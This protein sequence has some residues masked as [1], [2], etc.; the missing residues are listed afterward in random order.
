MTGIGE[1][2]YK[3]RLAA[4]DYNYEVRVGIALR[5]AERKAL[6]SS[7]FLAKLESLLTPED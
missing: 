6:K 1:A 3:E 5:K 4:N 7:D 2:I